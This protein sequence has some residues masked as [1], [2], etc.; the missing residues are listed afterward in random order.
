MT[1]DVAPRSLATVV[2]IENLPVPRCAR[3]RRERQHR[4]TSG[5]RSWEMNHV[6]G[7][8]LPPSTQ[9]AQR[10]DGFSAGFA[11]SA[12]TSM[13]EHETIISEFHAGAARAPPRRGRIVA[14]VRERAR[15]RGRAR[16]WWLG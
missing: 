1:T 9:R 3:R 10:R 14:D 7:D 4:W 12:V 5:K 15:A 13:P 11:I 2:A 8:G 6:H 16:G